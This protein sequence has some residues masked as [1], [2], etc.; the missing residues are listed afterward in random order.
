MGHH[1][2]HHHH[3]HHDPH[4]NPLIALCCCPCLLVSSMF[5]MIGR[6]VAAACYPV[7]HCFGLAHH[8]HHHHHHG[9]YY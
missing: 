8:H 1:G 4:D 6:C 9:H 2:H 3:H 7:L 5:E